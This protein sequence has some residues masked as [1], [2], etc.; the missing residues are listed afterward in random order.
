MWWFFKYTIL[1]VVR[2]TN[3]QDLGTDLE[4]SFFTKYSYLIFAKY[5]E[6]NLSE[7]PKKG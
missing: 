4:V 3:L 1:S 5:L 2:A 6:W 7:E